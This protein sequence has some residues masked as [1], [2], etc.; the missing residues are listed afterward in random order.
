[1]RVASWESSAGALAAFLNSA[2]ETYMADLF[3]FT[4]ASGTV[5]RYTS[6]DTPV[7]VN[8]LAYALGPAITRGKT[9]I[10]VGISVDTLDVTINADASVLVGSVPI[11]PFIANGGVDLARLAL[12][13]AFAA[14]PGSPWVGTLGLFQGRVSDVT[15]TRYEAVLTIDSDA[16]LLNVMVPRNVYQPGCLN[17]LFDATCLLSKASFAVSATATSATDAT[18]TIFSTALG[19][20][21]GYFALGYAVG[22]TGAN[23]GVAL[24]IRAFASGVITTIRPWPS[25]VGIGDTFTVYPGCDKQQATCSSKFSNL[26]NF[27][28]QPWIPAAM[29]VI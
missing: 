4:L 1:M 16:A 25:A 13:R 22:L 21:S 17:T 18:R 11:L 10:S 29:T 9:K 8:G 19:Q 23:A 20:A 3:T 7:T 6:A 27:R 5:I 28:G 2:T 14:A 26:A 12:D 15:V 24:S